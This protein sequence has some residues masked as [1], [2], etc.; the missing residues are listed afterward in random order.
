MTPT[1]YDRSVTGRRHA[2]RIRKTYA[3]WIA[4]MDAREGRDRNGFLP[5]QRVRFTY[6]RKCGFDHVAACNLLLDEIEAAGRAIG[7]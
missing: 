7:G 5:M 3:R 4:D 6:W 1:E 2:A